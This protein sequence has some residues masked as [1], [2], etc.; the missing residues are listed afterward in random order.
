MRAGRWRRVYVYDG[1]AASMPDTPANQR[2]YPQPE[3]QQPGLGF[4]LVRLG[5]A[6]S[7]ACGAVN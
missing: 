6:F 4:P 5:V 7:L 2:G 1:S 3:T